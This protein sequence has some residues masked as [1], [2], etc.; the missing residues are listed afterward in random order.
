MPR[1]TIALLT[2]TMAVMLSSVPPAKTSQPA[3]LEP[4][5][6]CGG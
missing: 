2:L 5:G 6:S 1:V 3:G 4:Q